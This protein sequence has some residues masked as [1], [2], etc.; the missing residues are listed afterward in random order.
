[1]FG[2]HVGIFLTGSHMFSG[3]APP[4]SV[5]A[6]LRRANSLN[7]CQTFLCDFYHSE[8]KTLNLAPVN[9]IEIISYF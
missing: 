8:A 4:P 5:K 7:F 9:R 2:I 1:M 6:L 3:F